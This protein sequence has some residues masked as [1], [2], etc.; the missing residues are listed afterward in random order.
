MAT[1]NDL[2]AVLHRRCNF[3][4]PDPSDLSRFI[5]ETP[6]QIRIIGRIRPDG[7]SAAMNNWLLIMSSLFERME[8]PG[9]TWKADISKWYF[10]RNGRIVFAWRI[11]LQGEDIKSR[12]TEILQAVNNSPI[13]S[14]AEVEEIP[15]PGVGRANRNVSHNGKGAGLSGKV[16]VGPMAIATMMAGKQGG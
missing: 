5:Q 6:K 10:R 15:L 9:V 4:I 14:K 2:L 7:T 8:K 12:L 1:V 13:S 11:L 16:A 3:E